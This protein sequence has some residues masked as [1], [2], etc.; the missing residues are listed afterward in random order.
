MWNLPTR[1]KKNQGP[2]SA[3][4]TPGEIFGPAA[5]GPKSTRST[6][7]RNF[8]P[9]CARPEIHE[10]Y[11]H[12]KFLIPFKIVRLPH[13]NSRGGVGHNM[14]PWFDVHRCS[15]RCLAEIRFCY[16]CPH[17]LTSLILF[18]TSYYMPLTGWVAA[19]A[20]WPI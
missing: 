15:Q 1:R 6:P 17:L 11:P 10:I 5:R 9:R 18:I 14:H 12:E 7:T 8:R 4:Y 16:I 3:R 20:D 19:Q 2:K 13:E